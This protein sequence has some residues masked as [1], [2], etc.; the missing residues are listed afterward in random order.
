MI[1]KAMEFSSVV[2]ISTRALFHKYFVAIKYRW[3][4]HLLVLSKSLPLNLMFI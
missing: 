2:Y 4:C 3:I 1:T